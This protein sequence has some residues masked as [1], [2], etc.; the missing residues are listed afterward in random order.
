MDE[1]FRLITLRQPEAPAAAKPIALFSPSSAFQRALSAVPA[2]PGRFAAIRDRAAGFMAGA[3]FVG[4]ASR[5]AL[6]AKLGAFFD[7]LSDPKTAPGDLAKCA[8]LVKQA[9]GTDAATTVASA[10][11]LKDET[12]VHDAIVALFVNPQGDLLSGLVRAAR[13]IALVR[14]V[15]D[16]DAALDAPGAVAAAMMQSLLLPSPTFPIVPTQVQPIGVADLLVVKQHSLRYEAGEIS[17]IENVLSGETKRHGLKHTLTL[18]KTSL[19]EEETTTETAK[20]LQTTERFSLRTEAQ[21]ALQE[22]LSVQAGVAVSASYGTLQLNTNASVAYANAKSSSNSTAI[23]R[24]KEVVNKAST[25][26]IDRVRVQQTS[27][28]TETFK[29]TD[30]HEYTNAA[31]NPNV[32]GIY[33]W[34]NEVYRAQVFNYGKRLLFDVTVPEPA[35]FLIDAATVPAKTG[36]GAPVPKQPD[37]FTIQ[38]GELSP[39]FGSPTYYGTYAKQFGVVGIPAPPEDFITVSKAIA[40]AK[41]EDTEQASDVTIPEGYKAIEAVVQA[42]YNHTGSK[43]DSGLVVYVGTAQYLLVAQAEDARTGNPR[44]LNWHFE[45]SFI[46]VAV[47]TWGAEN[48]AVAVDIRCQITDSHLAA[49]KN[50]VYDAILQARQ[51]LMDDYLD[52]LAR[53]Q[54]DAP[55]LGPLG[56]ANPEQNRATER[57]EL[58]KSCL[59]MLSGLDLLA[60]DGVQEDPPLPAPPPAHLFPRVDWPA[61]TAVPADVGGQARLIRFF[62]QAFEWPEMMYFFYPYFWGRKTTWYDRA[63]L[64][65]TDPL[66]AQFLS[67]GAARVVIPVRPGFETLVN[68]FLMTGEVWGGG[69]LPLVTDSAYLP[70]TEEIR[71]ASGAPGNE[72]PVGDAWE[73][74]LPTTLIKLRDDHDTPEWKQDPAD[75]WRWVVVK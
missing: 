49:W 69:A 9:F 75:Q 17:T 18:E 71:E 55:S 42:M 39:T 34:V 50:K 62:E 22:N 46:P 12:S 26:V 29:D 23:D 25:K 4:D 28:R 6:A 68:Y 2:G 19:Q 43:A 52:A 61:V 59:A 20:D 47:H 57:V 64:V 38:P 44:A 54:F 14:R 41:K 33:Q 66:F 16:K 21:N 65:N 13:L 32:V 1:L 31:T 56:G 30:A 73:V 67:A 7:A 63:L 36:S 51:K 53:Q 37:D 3:D 27:R 58:K 10:D 24:A 74:R 11:F 8:A 15:A 70:I 35:A 72:V 45:T 60:F 5:L 40:V 48:Y